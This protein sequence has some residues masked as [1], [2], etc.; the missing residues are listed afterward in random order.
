MYIL[1]K[2]K[3]KLINIAVLDFPNTFH[4]F[5]LKIWNGWATRIV[6]PIL[7]TRKV[8]DDECQNFM[9]HV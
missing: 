6:K 5:D 9:K 4:N 2:K 1:G 7:K 8:I 3:P